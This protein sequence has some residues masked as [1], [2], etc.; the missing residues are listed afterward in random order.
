MLKEFS[1]P[2]MQL[3]SA[4]NRIRL[5]NAGLGTHVLD[6]TPFPPDFVAAVVT[7]QAAR[8]GGTDE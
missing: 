8:E 2:L 3:V 5:F 4:A 7:W 1:R 6:L